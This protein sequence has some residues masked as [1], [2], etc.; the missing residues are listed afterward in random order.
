MHPALTERPKPR[1]AAAGLSDP[2]KHSGS[3]A[4]APRRAA[5]HG[6][7]LPAR[8]QGA[9][10]LWVAG[11]QGRLAFNCRIAHSVL[12]QLWSATSTKTIALRSHNPQLQPSTALDPLAAPPPPT[13]ETAAL[14]GGGLPNLAAP[15]HGV[16]LSWGL[17]LSAAALTRLKFFYS[18]RSKAL[19]QLFQTLV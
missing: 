9:P 17:P 2:Q 7:E 4:P 3:V 19:L 18:A 11:L 6:D 5:V 10:P 13:H 12:A 14:P 16:Q 15:T 8:V 1:G